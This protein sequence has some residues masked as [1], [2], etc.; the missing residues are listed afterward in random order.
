MAQG[1]QANQEQ[2]FNRAVGEAKRQAANVADAT[3]TAARK[4]VGSFE[5]AA[6]EVIENQPYTAV[7]IALAIGWVLGRLHRP[8]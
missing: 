6:R 2:G 1:Y 3:S 8:L 5:T 4:T 7:A